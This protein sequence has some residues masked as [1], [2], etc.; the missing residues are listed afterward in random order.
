MEN[1]RFFYP[2]MAKCS[3]RSVVLK[4]GSEGILEV[5]EVKP[6]QSSPAVNGCLFSDREERFHFFEWVLW[7]ICQ[8]RQ[9]YFTE[10][11]FIS[12]YETIIIINLYVCLHLTTNGVLYHLRRSRGGPQNIHGWEPLAY[13][14][15]RF[16]N[17]RQ[18][19]GTAP[20]LF[21]PIQE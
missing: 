12:I 19:R 21:S 4:W 14:Y 16:N 15:S 2:K 10:P 7:W 17:Y 3:R 6:H 13:M 5:R 20:S 18:I 11:L 8:K 1:A 9:V